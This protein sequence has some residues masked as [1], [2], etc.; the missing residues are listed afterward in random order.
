MEI[1]FNMTFLLHAIGILS[2]SIRHKKIAEVLSNLEVKAP[3]EDKSNWISLARCLPLELRNALILELNAGNKM[4][5][6]GSSDWPNPGSIVV[7]ISERFNSANHNFSPEVQW[8]NL[9]DPHYARE[10]LSQKNQGV[11]HLI[12][13]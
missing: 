5:G 2:V 4:T 6:I 10:E 1:H 7:N 13:T 3:S 9:N 12:I 8:K 11:E